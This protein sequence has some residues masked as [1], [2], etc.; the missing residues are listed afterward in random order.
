MKQTVLLF[1]LCLGFLGSDAQLNLSYV[2][3]FTY[4]QDLSDVWGYQHPD[5][6]EYA[7]VGARNGVSVV[8]LADPANPVEVAYASGASSGWRDIKTWGNYAYVTNETAQGVAVLN[9]TH[10]PDSMPFFNWTPTIPGQGTINECHNIFIDENGVAY[11][12]G[13][14]INGGG[15]ILVDVDSDPGN[16][17]YISSAPAENSHDV[18]VRGDTIYSSEINRGRLAIYNATDK[19]NIALLATQAT[20]ALATHN[21][22]LSDN[23]QYIFTTD[24]TGNAPVTSY[25]ISDLSDIQELDQYRPYA[26]LGDGV[27]PHNVHV[28]NDFIIVSYYTDG[29]LILDAH[30]PENL[31][32]VGNFDTFIPP[33]TGF[34]GVWGAYPFLPSGLVL[35]TDISNGLYILEP[36]YVR[37]CYLEGTV[38]DADNGNEL[39]GVEITVLST[40]AIEFTSIQGTYKT[41]QAVAATYQVQ[42]F[43]PGYEVAVKDAVLVN[44]EI[45][46]VDFELQSLPSFSFTGKI[47]DAANNQP[48][49]NAAVRIEN[50]Q[51][52]FDITADN[53]GEFA[54]NTFFEGTYDIFAGKW[55]YQTKLLNSQ[56]LN[57]TNSTI[58]IALNRGI[59]DIFSLDL[60]WDIDDNLPFTDGGFER[61]EPVL[62]SVNG[63]PGLNNFTVQPGEDVPEDIG[64][65]C[66]I[67]GNNADLQGGVVI[68]GNTAIESPGFDISTYNEPRIS[69]YT[70]YF[71]INTNNFMPGNDP[72]FVVLSNGAQ[73]VF[74]DTIEY[75]TLDSVYWMY[76][77]INVNDFMTPSSNMTVRFIASSPDFSDAVEAGIDYFR[78][79]DAMPVPTHDLAPITKLDIY[80]NPSAHSFTLNYELDNSSVDAQLVIFNVLGRQVASQAIEVVAGQL[81]FGADLPTGI[82]L[83]QIQQ[84]GKVSKTLRVLKQQP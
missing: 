60:G 6:T 54:I 35:A 4:N 63:I 37:A 81:N 21:A 52:D 53:S 22:W 19:Q 68:G 24:E 5:G 16:P 45:T 76:K 69:Y 84:D 13:C 49:A 58:T 7:I 40:P 23:S 62:V 36:N 17:Q 61:G 44:G 18:Y 20:P 10:L 74:I 28:W 34:Q 57:P 80:P 26:T 41:G 51:F 55:G 33:S 70:W 73:N 79:W 47:V 38:T 39:S 65:H 46:I 71:N 15:L 67:T 12:A 27:I 82:Y 59:E 29:C 1:F 83:V 2:S 8:S 56:E 48:I 50:P 9:L 42:A 32:E 14:N 75:N 66:F 78:V 43:K 11:L 64:N 77:E 3:D 25:D 30:R 72:M 31:V